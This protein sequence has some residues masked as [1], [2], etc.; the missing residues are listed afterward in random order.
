M[1]ADFY[2]RSKKSAKENAFHTTTGDDSPPTS[3]VDNPTAGSSTIVTSIEIMPSFAA[4]YW[5]C[6]YAG[7][8]AGE[9]I[10]PEA[11]W[12]RFGTLYS[13]KS[14]ALQTTRNGYRKKS[15]DQADPVTLKTTNKDISRR[16]E[17]RFSG[18]VGKIDDRGR[19]EL[20]RNTASVDVSR[21]HVKGSHTKT[22]RAT[23]SVPIL[24]RSFQPR[25]S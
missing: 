11:N 14:S 23:V 7:Q 10:Q 25:M 18:T 13:K 22:V 4:K 17:R 16:S 3:W 21:T 20:E 5:I 8:T 2:W 6:G 1:C 15:D 9:T 24:R 12:R 19:G